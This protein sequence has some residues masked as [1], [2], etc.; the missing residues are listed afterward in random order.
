MR[1]VSSEDILLYLEVSRIFY[2]PEYQ[3]YY[4]PE[5]KAASAGHYKQN[6]LRGHLQK[7]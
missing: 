6:S 3:V 7:N 1:R 4:T 5:V 2:V